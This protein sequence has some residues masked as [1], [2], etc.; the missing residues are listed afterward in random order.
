MA[1]DARDNVI[2]LKDFV[3]YI[4]KG[5]VSVCGLAFGLEGFYFTDLHGEAGFKRLKKSYGNIWK[6]TR[7]KGEENGQGC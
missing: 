1:V 2:Y 5:P 7:V 4:G 3:R 6:I